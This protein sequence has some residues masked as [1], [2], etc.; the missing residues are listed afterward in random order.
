M[1]T[2]TIYK[3]SILE[4][5]GF[6]KWAYKNVDQITIV[7]NDLETSNHSEDIN[8][9]RLKVKFN[10]ILKTRSKKRIQVFINSLGRCNSDKWL[11]NQLINI[12]EGLK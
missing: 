10:V 2:L 7:Y 11:K 4:R 8:N 1:K 3:R 5:T 6:K 12:L 9:K